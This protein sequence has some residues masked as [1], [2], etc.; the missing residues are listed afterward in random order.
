MDGFGVTATVEGD[1]ARRYTE[2]ERQRFELA[3]AARIAVG[4]VDRPR[5]LFVSIGD[6]EHEFRL[7]REGVTS[8]GVMQ[9]QV[10]GH[11][12]R[13]AHWFVDVEMEGRRWQYRPVADLHEFSDADEIAEHAAS[14]APDVR[15]V[16]VGTSDGSQCQDWET[17][18]D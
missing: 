4:L 3:E 17:R 2:G 12:P 6:G 10:E 13:W 16:W 15:W 7:Y 9:E 18:E 14:L 11:G 8:Y 1:T 5:T